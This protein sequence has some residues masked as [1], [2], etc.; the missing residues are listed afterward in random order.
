M[1]KSLTTRSR[2]NGRAR[3]NGGARGKVAGLFWALPLSVPR[4]RKPSLKISDREHRADGV[5]VHCFAGCNWKDVKAALIGLELLAPLGAVDLTVRPPQPAQQ[6]PD[7]EQAKRIDYAL[8]LWDISKPLRVGT[9]ETLGWRYF[10][11]TRK[12]PLDQLGDLSHALRWHDYGSAVMALMTDAVTGSPCGIH[13]TIVKADG[14]NRERK[15]LGRQ[16]VVRLVPDEDVTAGLGVTEGIEDGIA[17]MLSGWAPV[18]AATSAGAIER[19]PVMSGIE[20]L[21][22][23]AD[24]D[25]AGIRSADV[26]A[27]RWRSAGRQVEV[28]TP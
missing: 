11:Y 10:K 13:R 3:H 25:E 8:S 12:L 16:G 27:T 18:W 4:R 24:A 9:R 7:K 26:C 28:K 21:T 6:K 1:P 19:F 17:V 5:D 2:S 22:I 14:S 20:H 15:M 23:F